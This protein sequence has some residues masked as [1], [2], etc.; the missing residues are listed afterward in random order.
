MTGV[1]PR[2]ASM[3]VRF[4]DCVLDTDA[5]QLLR[6]TRQVALSP[7]AFETLKLLVEERPRA[8]SKADM[9]ERVWRGVFVSDAS[10]TRVINEVR[11]GVGDSARTGRTIRTVHAFGYA[12]AADVE[13]LAPLPPPGAGN[14]DRCWLACGD[15]EYPLVDGEH[16]IGREPGLAVRLDSPKVSRRHARLIVRGG[17]ATLEDLGSKNGTFVRGARIRQPVAIQS[18]DPIRVGGFRL[19]LHRSQGLSTTESE[20]QF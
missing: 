11:R 8:L 5:R 14:A 15:R 7:K 9:L 12:F 10:L 2:G 4:G 1:G 6:G 18:G 19:T 16:L 20:T 17:V 3:R 13:E